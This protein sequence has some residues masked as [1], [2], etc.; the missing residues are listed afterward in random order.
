MSLQLFL[1][2][3]GFSTVRPT[4]QQPAHVTQCFQGNPAVATFPQRDHPKSAKH[5]PVCT[6]PRAPYVSRQMNSSL[7]PRESGAH[8]GNEGTIL[9][10]GSRKGC[11]ARFQHH[12]I[13]LP[14]LGA[15][16][17]GAGHL[18]YF[19]GSEK[20]DSHNSVSIWGTLWQDSPWS[21][22]PPHVLTPCSARSSTTSGSP[23]PLSSD[24]IR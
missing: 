13:P 3:A 23:E 16:F 24:T 17:L 5:S 22:P 2:G 20:A 8:P 6:L 19:P 1:P 12:E 10:T 9:E 15:F 11:D 21:S 7:L 14:H 18:I 4:Y